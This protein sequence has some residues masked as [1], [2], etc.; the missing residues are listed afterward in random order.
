M[1]LEIVDVAFDQDHPHPTIGEVLRGQISM[2]QQVAVLLVALGQPLGG[3]DQFAQADFTVDQALIVI[4]Q[5]TQRID[6]AAFETHLAQDD[7]TAAQQ[8]LG[9]GD[10]DGQ[11]NPRVARP[12]G[13]GRQVWGGQVSF[14]FV[15][16]EKA[17]QG[18]ATGHARPGQPNNRDSQRTHRTLHD[19][20]QYKAARAAASSIQA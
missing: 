11:Q 17:R 1:Q 18:F 4:A 3:V 15:A 13:I 10:R 6:A 9:L 7:P 14:D 2:G 19:P 20:E 5:V 16:V 12:I 8:R